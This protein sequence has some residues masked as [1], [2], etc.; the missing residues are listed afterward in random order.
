MARPNT[1]LLRRADQFACR[2]DA[3]SD[4]TASPGVEVRGLIK[5]I[6]PRL[7]EVWS[8]PT[9]ANLARY[10]VEHRMPHVSRTYWAAS[11]RRRYFGFAIVI[12]GQ[13]PAITGDDA[14]MPSWFLINTGGKS[15]AL[16]S[17]ADC[18][19]VFELLNCKRIRQGRHL[20]HYL[21]YQSTPLF[22][23]VLCDSVLAPGPAEYGIPIR[24]GLLQIARPGRLGPGQICN[25]AI[26]SQCCC[27]GLFLALACFDK[28]RH[29]ECDA[30]S[31][32]PQRRAVERLARPLYSKQWVG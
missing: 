22:E 21:H 1:A 18:A 8:P 28:C 16:K 20:A 10:F 11:S 29:S 32:A 24:Q 27:C 5:R 19:G 9:T 3:R 6:T 7:P 15:G 14:K 17:S 13:R 26:H 25:S 12:L 2:S 4:L 31:R 30:S 23:H